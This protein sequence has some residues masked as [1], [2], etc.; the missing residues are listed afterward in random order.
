MTDTNLQP[1]TAAEAATPVVETAEPATAQVEAET[2]ETE[3]EDSQVQKPKGGFQRRIDELTRNWREA[4]RRN[5]Q[6]LE[7]VSRQQGAPATQQQV[8]DAGKPPS[9]ADFNYDESKYQDALL[10]FA[11]K[12]AERTVTA[13]L[14]EWER[15]QSQQRQAQT[16]K[17]KE[18]AFAATVDDYADKVYDP[19]VPIS[20]A[21]AEA[22]ADSDIG[23]ML[24]YHLA[25][26]REVAARIA[27]LSPV[28]AA[29]E[30]GKIEAQLSAPKQKPVT[31]APPPP[32][33][34][35]GTGS[36]DMPVK[37]SDPESDKLEI[38]EWMRRRDLEVKRKSR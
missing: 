23:P 11:S 15:S 18:A 12:A 26:N 2:P 24:A 30:L 38:N 19:S 22:I 7:L 31:K 35:Q 25:D 14:S 16:F 13:K 34:I 9:L 3:S 28:Q 1:E 33:K 37:A 20:A 32:P 21:M 27:A 4:E 10:S 8:T 17:A 5:D 36:D 6:L 29:R